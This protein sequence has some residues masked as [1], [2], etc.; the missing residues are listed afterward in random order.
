[1]G[2]AKAKKIVDKFGKNTIN[3]LKSQPEMLSLIK[4]ITT[5]K[6][7]VISESFTESYELWQIVGFLE[8]FGIGP[9]KCKSIIQKSLGPD[10]IIKF[11]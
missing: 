8:K 3:V 2:P 9:S 6:A 11:Q 4:G 1:M 5:E 10:A 7:R